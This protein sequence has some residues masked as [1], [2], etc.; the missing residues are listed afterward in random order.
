MS[1]FN[2]THSCG[3]EVEHQL[4]GPT[5]DRERKAD[6]LAGTLCTA[7]WKAEQEKQRADQA[8]AAAAENQTAGACAL[9][10]SEA[11]VRWAETIRNRSLKLVTGMLSKI[12][13]APERDQQPAAL[14]T[15]KDLLAW[16]LLEQSEAKWWIESVGQLKST[17]SPAALFSVLDGKLPAASDS[18]VVRHLVLSF[19][20]LT[21]ADA[22]V[23]GLGSE[24]RERLVS[25]TA[26]DAKSELRKELEA[27]KPTA[28]EF[29]QDIGRKH[30]DNWHCNGKIYSGNRV[31]VNNTEYKLTDDQ[32]RELQAY[33][34]AKAA[35]SAEMKKLA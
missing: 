8:T 31:Y 18:E 22:E 4:F 34:T 35:W 13:A 28:P 20:R 1:K 17:S 12:E 26:A 11:Q 29:W 25:A 10:G 2:I 16:L 6:W 19:P 15:V 27:K 32:A 3:H 23:F 9:N 24:F 33:W 5:K 14:R 30:A 21:E 7:C